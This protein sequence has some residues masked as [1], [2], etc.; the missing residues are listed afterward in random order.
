MD[1]VEKPKGGKQESTDSGGGKNSKETGE[2]D[3]VQKE[4]LDRAREANQGAAGPG[5]I[6][7]LIRG[8]EGKVFEEEEETSE[9]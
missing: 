5:T 8:L 2:V 9:E 1:E 3:T 7:D 6:R 4:I